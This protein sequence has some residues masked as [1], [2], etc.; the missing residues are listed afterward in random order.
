[1]ANAL[2]PYPP[3]LG[4]LRQRKTT[5]AH[6]FMALNIRNTAK[7]PLKLKPIKETIWPYLYII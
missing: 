1:M 5:I 3:S 6:N 2:P 4:K 7:T